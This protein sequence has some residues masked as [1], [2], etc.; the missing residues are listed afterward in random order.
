MSTSTVTVVSDDIAD[1]PLLEAP[2]ALDELQLASHWDEIADWPP[3]RLLHACYL[4]MSDQPGLRAVVADY[5]RQLASV[6]GLDLILPEWLHMSVQ[7]L[8]FLDEVRPESVIE[9]AW[10][11][12]D[13]F[14]ALEPF[15]V[16]VE[17]PEAV[18][19]SIL[20]PVRPIEPV[21]RLR[22]QVRTLAGEHGDFGEL[23]VLP[24]QHGAF[25]PHISIAYANA[26]VSTRAVSDALARCAREPVPILASRLSMV[27][28]A[29]S[30]RKYH[31]LDERLV[32][33]GR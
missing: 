16:T 12:D 3:E 29:R 31:W 10:R 2:S 1:V 4:T 24:G 18:G 26:P 19:D 7:G 15:E 5:Q 9:L 25:D 30:D 6:P 11:L 20:M 14:A 21:A 32:R 33:L 8:C 22:D 13:L 17:R 27:T 28:L 23:F